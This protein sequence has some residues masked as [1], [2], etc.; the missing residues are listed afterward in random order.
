MISNKGLSKTDSQCL[1]GIA[2]ILLIYHHCF[3]AATR[4]EGYAVDFFPFTQEGVID[5]SYFCKICV[6][7]FAFISGYGLYCSASKNKLRPKSCAKWTASRLIKTLSGFW[8]VYLLVLILSEVFAGFATERYCKNDM[9]QGAVYGIIDFLGLANAFGTPTLCATWWYMSAAIFFIAVIPIFVKYSDEFGFFSLIVLLVF[10]PRVLP[11][12]FPGTTTAYSFAVILAI[13]MAFAK[14]NIFE[15][16]SKL[17]WLK[18]E[19][20]D[21]AL[22]FLPLLALVVISEIVY[23]RVEIEEFWELHYAI[24]PMIFIYFCKEYIVRIPVVK[25][26]LAFF[27]KHSMN[28]FLVHTFFRY[29][30]FMDF[31][32]SFE[33]FW[34]IALVLFGV[35]LGV[36]IVI[37]ALKKLIRYDKFIK[38]FS[39]KVCLLI[40]KI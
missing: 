15:R 16:L 9:I 22:K 25:Q 5:F 13:G 38:V 29:T 32:Y 39:D 35:S 12:G 31:T 30:F 36:S 1:K 8:V 2:I 17:K 11:I 10:I 19:K 21:K 33:K 7:I 3:A 40:D 6:S 26:V 14:Y 18:N 34:R 37:E 23:N 20:A 27:G 4:F 28:I 24:I